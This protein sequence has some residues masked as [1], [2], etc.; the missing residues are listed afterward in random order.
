[1]LRS[2]RELERY[3]VSATDGDVGRVVNFLFDDERWTIRYLVVETGSF[4][5]E[6]RVLISPISFRQ[7]DLPTHLFHVALTMDKVMGS[8]GVAADEPVSRQR[9]R[10][11]NRYYGYGN[12]W[13]GGVWGA[14]YTPTLLESTGRSD[15]L[16]TPGRD[17][18]DA[19]LQSAEDVRGYNIEGSHAGIGF[20]TDFLVDD[21]T[22]EVRY[23]VVD[24]SHWWWRKT[25]LVAP[26]W[27]TQISWDERKM[28][29]TL[30][31]DAVKRS[32]PWNGAAGIRR[33]YEVLL[34]D[35]HRRPGYWVGRDLPVGVPRLQHRFRSRSA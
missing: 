22:W 28:F 20:I 12:Y 3:R 8:P 15:A 5:Q 31:R 32:P 13:G 19:H 11:Y 23:L 29:V 33:E 21:E 16:E 30:S 17:S 35:Y 24:T 18:G 9:E 10:E 25:V 14:G 34:H 2:L 26:N 6:R 4:F 7:L 1:M 27:A